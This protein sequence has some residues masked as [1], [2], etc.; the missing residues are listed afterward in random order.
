MS[1]QLEYQLSTLALHPPSPPHTELQRH[2]SS[3]L[4]L[5]LSGL[6]ILLTNMPPDLTD[7]M[8]CVLNFSDALALRHVNRNL[9]H[10][11]AI[12]SILQ[13]PFRGQRL[14]GSCQAEIARGW[15]RTTESEGRNPGYS[16]YVLKGFPEGWRI[17]CGNGPHNGHIT[18]YCESH[19]ANVSRHGTGGLEEQQPPLYE[20]CGKHRGAAHGA[21]RFN[22]SQSLHRPRQNIAEWVPICNSCTISQ[23]VKSPNGSNSCCCE[24]AVAAE[25]ALLAQGWNCDGCVH[26]LAGLY[27]RKALNGFLRILLGRAMSGA[28]VEEMQHALG[29][30]SSGLGEEAVEARRKRFGIGEWFTCP[31]CGEVR[32]GDLG[33]PAG[34]IPQVELCL[35][36]GGIFYAVAGSE[37][38]EKRL[39]RSYTTLTPRTRLL[40]GLGIITWGGLGLLVTD[41]AEKKFNMVPTEKDREELEE[42][43]PRITIVERDNKS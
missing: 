40:L 2:R 14:G 18:R 43:M 38:A 21:G 36:C 30:L 19:A 5:S 39:R 37:E 15:L 10:S 31:L 7:T 23:I 22:A 24:A 42:A 32:A 29:S 33:L 13:Q 11:Y 12:N 4:N 35:V 9:A 41:Q 25:E 26:R 1:S 17:E 34:Q 20:V 8:F 16:I 3:A 6:E 28:T 27:E